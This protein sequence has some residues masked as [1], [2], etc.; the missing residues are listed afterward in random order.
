MIKASLPHPWLTC[1]AAGALA[2]AGFGDWPLWPLPILSLAFLFRESL[3]ATSAKKAFVLGFSWG[4]TFFLCGVSWVYVSLHTFGMMPAALAA[5]GTL[6]FCLFLALFPAVTSYL[7]RR[8]ELPPAIALLVLAPAAW[9][10]NEWIRG[11][12][13]TGFPWLALGYSQIDGPLEGYAPL[14]GVFGI[15]LASGI[16]ASALALLVEYRTHR[17][18]IAFLIGIPVIGLLCDRIE[19]TEGKRAPISVALI[20]GNIPQSLKFVPGRYESTL[21]TYAKLAEEAQAKL[22]VLPEI[23]IP[24]LLSNVDPAYLER[25][26]GYALAQSG[27]MILPVPLMDE[28]GAYYNAAISIGSSPTQQYAKSHL[29]PFGEFVPPGFGWI[30]HILHIPMS[31]FGRGGETQQPLRIAGEAVAINICYED[32]FGE[33]IIRQLPEASLLVN[34]SNV[35]WFG[36]SLAPAQHLKISRMRA[37]ETRRY[38]LRATNTGVT[39]IIDARGEVTARL[40]TFN[41]GVLHGEARGHTG[42][43]PFVRIGNWATVSAASLMFAFAWAKSRRRK[44]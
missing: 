30:I 35:A 40:P 41:E 26:R 10:L 5:L 22:I 9:A 3:R 13:F 43:T 28:A 12:I 44:T 8:I 14:I 20:Q 21:R 37:I 25:L 36:D 4:V 11:W 38:M 17:L 2:V 6:L 31:D 29:V 16:W 42:A 27:D 15:S 33:E 19:W 7:L 23:A 1:A 18:A 39:A 34:V 32:A 24:R